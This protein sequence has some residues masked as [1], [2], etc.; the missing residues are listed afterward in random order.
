M[1]RRLQGNSCQSETERGT[2]AFASSV[3]GPVD[4]LVWLHATQRD[5]DTFS[6]QDRLRYS[7]YTCFCLHKCRRAKVLRKDCWDP[8]STSVK[9]SVSEAV[10]GNI[11]ISVKV[12]LS[13]KV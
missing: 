2:P 7:S 3:R 10:S 6:G 8:K 5:G 12:S 11:H 13:S 1:G 4:G 9:V